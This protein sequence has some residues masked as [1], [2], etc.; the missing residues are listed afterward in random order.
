MIM[1]SNELEEWNPMP[2]KGLLVYLKEDIASLD[3]ISFTDEDKR[4]I[5]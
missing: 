2:V 3:M 4:E 1:L 5:I